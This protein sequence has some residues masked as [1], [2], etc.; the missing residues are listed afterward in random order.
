VTDKLEPLPWFAFNVAEY[1]KDTM[2]L[3]TESHGAYLLLMLDYYGT[4]TPCPDDDFVLA[5]VAKLT[6][7]AWAKHRKVLAPFF[8]IREGHWYHNRI[9]RE[10]RDACAKHAASTAAAKA[11]AAARWG[12][13]GTKSATPM[14]PRSRGT[15]KAPKNADRNAPAVPEALPQAMPTQS[16]PIAHLHK[17]PLIT[18][19][20]KVP[21]A[22]EADSELEVGLIPKDFTPDPAISDRARAAGL[23]VADID[24]EVRKFMLKRAGQLG[25]DW[26]GSFALWIEREISY[27]AKQ[28]AKAPPRIEVNNTRQ[29]PTTTEIIRALALFAD[30]GSWSHKT[31]GPE[32][33]QIGCRVPTKLIEAAGIDPKTGMKRR[34]AS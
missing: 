5:A 8:D 23:S 1:V 10:M 12:K 19:G 27:R 22:P 30:G 13:E 18:G 9:E 11:G 29:E 33:G 15:A 25:S 4:A 34:A 20:E 16:D 17:H 26:Q 6:P 28:A 14:A 3:S 24:A 32:P 2:R 7:E 31:F 21:P